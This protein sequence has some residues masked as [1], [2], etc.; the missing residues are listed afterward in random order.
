[1]FLRIALPVAFVAFIAVI[2]INW[3]RTKIRRDKAA[4][5]P[6]V[7]TRSGETPQGEAKQ[8]DD[9][10]TIGG[11]VVS[12]IRAKRVVS[13]TSNWTTLEDVQLTIFRPN[14]LTYEIIC[15]TAQFNSV[16]K[17]ADA[18]GG[19][20]VT[21][22]DGIEIQTA[23]IKFDGNRLTNQIPVQFKIDRWTGKG[24][25]LDLDVQGETLR[26]FKKVNAL[27][28][29]AQ[30]TEAPMTLAG[31]DALFRRRENDV[32][33]T[34]DVVMTRSAD[35]ARADVVIGRFTQDR[36]KLIGLDGNGN[37]QMVMSS[38]PQP[39]EDLGGKKTITCD[40]FNTEV[41]AGGE[42][43]AIIARGGA[44]MAHAVL[45]GP[46]QR[47]IVARS[48]RVG[49]ANRA[50]SEI[51][52]ESQVVMKEFGEVQ[53]TVQA[54]HVT[55]SFDPQAHRATFASLEGAFRYSDPKTT[56]SAFRANYDIGNDRILLTTDP[57][58]DATV[59]SDGQ[60][61]KAKQIEFAPK[62]QTALAKG[63][64]IAQL[65]SKNSGA[66]ADATNLFP[67]GKPVFVNAEQLL[68]RQ[69]NKVA[70]FSGKV[71]A[72]QETNT[73]LANELQ[74]EGAG[75]LITA[76]GGVQTMLYNTTADVRKTPVT[77]TSDQLVARK[78]DRRIDLLGNVTIKDETR[79]L[80]SEKASFFFDANKKID[81]IEAEDKVVVAEG[82][83]SRRGTGDKAVYVVQKKM[84]YVNGKPAT[85]NDPSGSVS[86]EQIVFDLTRNKVQVVSPGGPTSGSYKH[87]G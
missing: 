77:S 35:S 87:P 67:S 10:Q 23:E 40:G 13:Y 22:T 33:F 80:T 62:S 47:D 25:A 83:T 59:V 48:F 56:A 18:K 26:L 37:A 31:D 28:T 6:V 27:M 8:F 34:K 70:V 51:K 41:G 39:G 46:P 60:V 84:I 86:G 5:Q 17:E 32:T 45:D 30:P 24:G 2:A 16:T 82:P 52:A 72:W 14:N 65:S 15:P 71:R 66:A 3:N 61:V 55:V 42:I 11:R 81:R 76:R 79:T 63:D 75:N 20:K 85:M 29:P 44:N 57:G 68:M 1:R 74:L 43:V 12:R 9:T 19:V 53:R 58:W 49:I 73:I 4:T 38:N 69:Q 50:V 21:S 54:E 78:G 64:V 36:H 7:G